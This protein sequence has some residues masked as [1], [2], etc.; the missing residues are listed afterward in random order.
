[1]EEAA[2]PG[3]VIFPTAAKD[4][5]AIE[6]LGKVGDSGC[7]GDRPGQFV[8]SKELRR[9]VGR[10]RVRVIA[11]A[12]FACDGGVTPLAITPEMAAAASIK[13]RRLDVVI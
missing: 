3:D 5:R 1:M 10:Q 7:L 8:L 12:A 2:I 11:E 13:P 9:D 6:P 4:E